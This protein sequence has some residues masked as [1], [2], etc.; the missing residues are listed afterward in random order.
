MVLVSSSA[1]AGCWALA[2]DVKKISEIRRA[3]AL[4]R[5]KKPIRQWTN[6]R[7][8]ALLGMTNFGR[9]IDT[10]VLNAPL[11]AVLA[12]TGIPVPPEVAKSRFTEYKR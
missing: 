3:N 5:K 10:V 4:R 1:A 12:T 8:L 2:P 6:P 11:V 9:A 7:F